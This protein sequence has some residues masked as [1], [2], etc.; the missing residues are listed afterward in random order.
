M[1]VAI[2]AVDL[3][4][5]LP[6]ERRFE[7]PG[8]RAHRQRLAEQASGRRRDQRIVGDERMDPGRPAGRREH[9]VHQE[10][11]GRFGAGAAGQRLA[12]F[13]QVA[14][15]HLVAKPSPGIPGPA[16]DHEHPRVAEQRVQ[17]R[18]PLQPRA[19]CEAAAGL[20][21]PEQ[22]AGVDRAQPTSEPLAE[23]QR[24]PVPDIR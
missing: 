24:E 8:P 4:V 11:R 7:E 3:P 19:L 9:V 14:H 18:R 6:E 13:D 2:R 21:R 23:R 10:S 20:H 5:L 1:P 12:L 16:I 15:D 17:P 22:R